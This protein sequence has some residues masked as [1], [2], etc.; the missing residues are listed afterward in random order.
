MSDTSTV[1]VPSPSRE[2]SGKAAIVGL[3][4]SDYH[5]D[6]KAER[7]RA[8]GYVSPTPEG[9]VR[10]AF[11]RA[12]TDSGLTHADIDGLSVSFIYGGPDPEPLAQMLGLKPR[13]LIANGNIMAGPLP[14]VCADIAAG[15]AD[16]VAMVYAA[17]SRAIGRQYGGKT[18][19]SDPRAP[20]A[21]ITT[22]TLGAGARRLPIGP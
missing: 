16:T 5:L 18:Y 4:E 9:L 12:L 1:R 3:G 6:Y 21:P 8:P 15:R 2:L 7:A 13:Y 19:V 11:Q 17:P 22:I 14:V 10:T 20:R